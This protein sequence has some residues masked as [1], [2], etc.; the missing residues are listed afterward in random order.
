MPDNAPNVAP[1][2]ELP[3]KLPP[4]KFVAVT[5]VPPVIPVAAPNVAPENELPVK[6][7]P[8]KFVAVTYVP[9]VI[10]VAAPNVLPVNAVPVM[11]WC[12]YE[13]GGCHVCAKNVGG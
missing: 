13:T 7:P 12:R 4:V 3:L 6:L 10:P 9:P 5:Y 2:N 1:E 11:I 8:V